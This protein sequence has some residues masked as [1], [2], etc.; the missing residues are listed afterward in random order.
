MNKQW[1]LIL[2]KRFAKGF[3]SGFV[4]SFLLYASQNPLADL[5]QLKPWLVSA[6][7]AALTG[8]IL[9]LEKML[10]GYNPQ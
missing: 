3:A 9:A 1:F 6:G 5:G 2:L 4:S 7:A 10:Q 8:G